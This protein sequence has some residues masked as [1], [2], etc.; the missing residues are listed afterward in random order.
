MFTRLITILLI[1]AQFS[2]LQAQEKEKIG[3]WFVDSYFGVADITQED[4]FQTIALANGITAGKRFYFNENWGLRLGIQYQNFRA[5][6]QNNNF[7]D[8]KALSLP[9]QAI[10]VYP[11]SDKIHLELNG[12]VY[13]GYYLNNSITNEVTNVNLQENNLG[14]YSG[15]NSFIG[16]RYQLFDKG[17]FIFGLTTQN[18]LF[19]AFSDDTPEININNLY[20]FQLGVLFNL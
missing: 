2:L 3:E 10:Y 13:L 12:G 14:F 18:D 6:I 8:S 17:G 4:T 1:G 5:N 16:L 11:F 9:M 7:F 19:Q 20:G 15:I